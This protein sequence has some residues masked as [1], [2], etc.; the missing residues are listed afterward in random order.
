M[1]DGDISAFVDLHTLRTGIYKR[2]ISCAESADTESI[3][4]SECQTAIIHGGEEVVHTW[5]GPFVIQLLLRNLTNHNISQQSTLLY[6]K[7]IEGTRVSYGSAWRATLN[8]FSRD[9]I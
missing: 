7:L 4:K 3:K 8:I 1:T 2:G 9:K 6:A 5:K